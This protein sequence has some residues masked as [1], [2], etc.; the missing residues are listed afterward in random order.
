M[1]LYPPSNGIFTWMLLSVMAAVAFCST[2]AIGANKITGSVRNETRGEPAIADEVILIRLDKVMQEEM[3]AKTDADGTFTLEVQFPDKPYLVRALHQDVSY[4]QGAVAGDKL[5]IEVFDAAPQVSRVAG[6]IEILRAGTKGNLLHVSDMIEIKNDS[7]PPLTQASQHTFD[8]YL[9]SNS[10]IDSVLAAA[11][12]KSAEIISA[13]RVP[14]EPGHYL[15][16]FPLR[17]GPTKFAFNYDLPYR[18]RAAIPTRHAY[19]L[20]QFAVMIP[21]SMKFSSGSPDFEI[22]ATSNSDYQ[23]RAITRVKAGEGPSFEVSGTGALPPIR[24]QTTTPTQVQLPSNPTASTQ[25]RATVPSS[26]RVASVA[27]MPQSS[28]QPL[29]FGALT[30]ALIGVCALLIWRTRKARGVTVT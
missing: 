24:S 6:T 17:P 10:K 26:A 20:Q 1:N 12:G 27:P 8:A 29:V 16:D 7:I 13:K 3:R 9:P 11:P 22:L 30:A 2:A 21:R 4:D 23:V 14:G 28:S 5:T 19:P 18:G 15:V 25:V